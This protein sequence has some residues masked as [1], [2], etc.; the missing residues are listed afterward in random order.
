MFEL[1]DKIGVDNFAAQAADHFYLI[2][3]ALLRYTEANPTG[4]GL[5]IAGFPVHPFGLTGKENK[6]LFDGDTFAVWHRNA[7]AKPGGMQFFAQ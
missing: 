5:V 6:R 7:R 2:V 4:D 1:G 3:L